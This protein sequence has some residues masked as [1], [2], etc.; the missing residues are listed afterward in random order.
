[1]LFLLTYSQLSPAIT[2]PVA[3]NILPHYHGDIGLVRVWFPVV[4]VCI[5]VCYGVYYDSCALYST[6]SP[7]HIFKGCLLQCS[8]QRTTLQLGQM[9]CTVVVFGE[10]ART[11]TVCTTLTMALMQR[12]YIAL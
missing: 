7:R 2:F 12:K 9:Q 6:K 1:M 10:G 4:C 3:L 5:C 8:G 11:C